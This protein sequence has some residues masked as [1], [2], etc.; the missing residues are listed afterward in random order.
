M[1]RNIEDQRF[2]TFLSFLMTFDICLQKLCFCK[3]THSFF[4]KTAVLFLET[5]TGFGHDRLG[6]RLPSGQSRQHQQANQ[7]ASQEGKGNSKACA[8]TSFPSSRSCS[9]VPLQNTGP[10]TNCYGFGGLGPRSTRISRAKMYGFAPEKKW[11][12]CGKSL[13]AILC[14]GGPEPR[15]TPN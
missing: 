3:S 8:R 2:S 11:F 14:F 12:C 1:Q 10:T 13:P 15:Y 4:L 7:S 6:K 5:L 9:H